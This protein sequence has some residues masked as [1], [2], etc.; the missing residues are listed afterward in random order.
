[1]PAT[2]PPIRIASRK[3]GKVP[4][5]CSNILLKKALEKA[6]T[7]INPAWPSESS[8]RIP[9]TRLSE[10]AIVAYTHRG[11]SMPSMWALTT[12]PARSACTT[13]KASTRRAIVFRLS[14]EAFVIEV[15]ILLSFPQTF[16]CIF[17][18]IRPVGFTRRTMMSTANTIAS[19]S[20]DEM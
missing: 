14:R 1:M 17:L 16:S 6:P 5:D 4:M 2:I 18:P 10:T 9:T 8:P 15:F 19:E 20:C 13:A 7:H 11:T 12:P 3:R